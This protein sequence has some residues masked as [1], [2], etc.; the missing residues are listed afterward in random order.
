M[1]EIGAG[2]GSALLLVMLAVA[3]HDL[4]RRPGFRRLA[5][6]NLVRRRTEAILVVAGSSLGTAIIASAFLVGASFHASVQDSARTTLGPIDETVI[7]ARLGDLGKVTDALGSPP[8]A[9]TDGV[10]PALR[11]TATVTAGDEFAADSQRS[12]RGERGGVPSTLRAEPSADVLGLDVSAARSFGGR[13]HDTGLA[14]VTAPLHDDEAVIGRSLADSLA[15]GVG[16]HLALHAFGAQRELDVVDVS[17]P[18]GLAGAADV[19]VA[20]DVLRTMAAGADDTRVAPLQGVVFV[21]NDGGI[22]DGAA[23]SDAVVASI[24]RRLDPHFDVEVTSSKADLL[25]EADQRGSAMGKLFTGVGT[26]SVLAGLLLLVNLFV[27]LAEER[28]R[29]LGLARA[30]GL[31]RWHLMRVFTLEGLAYASVAALVGCLV[32]TGISWVVVTSAARLVARG[33][34]GFALRLVVPSGVLI[35]A[36]L[37]GLGLSMA[38]VWITSGRIARLDIVRALRD[39]PEIPRHHHVLRSSLPAAIGVAVGAALSLWGL[40]AIIPLAAVLGPPIG[41]CSAIPLLQPVLGRRVTTAVV[42]AGTLVWC[43][44]V[45]TFVPRITDHTGIPVFVVQGVVMVAAAVGLATALDRAWLV[46]TGLV[47][48]TG[49]GLAIRLG[50]AYPLEKVFRTGMLVGMYALILFTLTFVAVYGQISENQESTLTRQIAAGADLL[51]DAGPSNPPTAAQVAAVPGVAG[52]QTVWRAAPQFTT[53]TDPHPSTWPVSGF[54]ASM[55]DWGVPHLTERAPGYRSDRAV[56]A[57]LVNDP[58]LIVVD[59]RFGADRDVPA[60]GQGPV[61]VGATIRARDPSTGGSEAF[62]VVGVMT[63]DVTRTGSWM[64]Q[65]ALL[66]LAGTSAVADRF[67]VRVDRGVDPETVAHRLQ[68]DLVT[69]GVEADTYA[70]KVA[71]SMSVELGFL[72]LMQR[73][74]SI[75][76]VVGIAGLAVVMVRAARARRRQVGILRVI[77]FPGDTVRGAFLVEATFIAGQGIAT[78]VGLGLLVSYQ[79]LSRSAALGGDVLPYAVPWPTIGLLAV[80]PFIASLAVALIPAAQAAAVEPAQVLRLAD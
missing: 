52:V 67:S 78:G 16:D 15:V 10:L 60:S 40:V 65:D 36:G 1:I 57:A 80:V 20:P 7:V 64:S 4:V 39:L 31:E 11:T 3:F 69:H 14:S 79:M 22:F 24:A 46:G 5:M 26:F 62:R 41:L 21:S 53:A 66:G 55:A 6:R 33:D 18:V 72:R 38:T 23:T 35:T 32:G 8:P 29:E 9:G 45:F 51:V 63:T 56:F 74:M 42:S 58:H 47:T 44:G 61:E 19:I 25:A 30:T 43:V 59:E 12:E 13:V 50:L 2:I 68:N 77:G 76:L 70:A 73:Y 54:T 37:I 48:R 34:E 75:G 27:M 28:K 17:D 49:R 71:E